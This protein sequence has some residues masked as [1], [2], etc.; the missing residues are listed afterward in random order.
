MPEPSPR[1]VA[2]RMGSRRT[3]PCRPAMPPYGMASGCGY[4]TRAVASLSPNETR[5]RA[6]ARLSKRPRVPV[7]QRGDEFGFG[8]AAERGAP[9]RKLRFRQVAHTRAVTAPKPLFKP[10]VEAADSNQPAICD[11]STS[12]QTDGDRRDRRDAGCRRFVSCGFAEC[13]EAV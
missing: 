11:S 6:A 2:G 3:L 12:T 4:R 5:R 1:L 10:A 7:F 9:G 8:R 13:E